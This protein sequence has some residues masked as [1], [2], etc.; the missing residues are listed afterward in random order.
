MAK[1][2]TRGAWL[3]TKFINWF[4]P[5]F[6]AHAFVLARAN[7]YEADACS[8]RL[9]GADAAAGAL[10]RLPVD[11][12]LLSEKFWPDLYARATQEEKPP[13]DVMLLL[14]QALK[15]GPAADDA[16][17]WLKQA[18]LIETNN[19]DTHPCLKDRLRAIGKLPT[20]PAILA[21]LTP[22]APPAQSAAEFFLDDQAAAAAHSM[23]NEWHQAIATQWTARHEHARKTAQE[24]AALE[25]PSD[26]P[27]KP[28]DLWEKARKLIDLHGDA[29]ALPVLRQILALDPKHAAANY[30]CGRHHLEKDEP[31]G[32]Q[33]IESALT[34][35][36]TLTPDGCNLLYGHFARTGQRDRLRPLEERMDQFQDVA[37][38]AQ[39]ERANITARDAFLPGELSATQTA[40]I[41]AVFEPEAEVASAAV[42]RKQVQHFPN[43]A[44]YVVGLRLK[45][46]WWKPRSSTASQKLIN[47]V[48]EKLELPGHFLV[49]VDEQNLRSL[50]KKVFAVPG[51]VV[52]ERPPKN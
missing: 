30:V 5:V 11:G 22:P 16:A 48:V 42:V 43:S 45:T 32:V 44:C 41:R 1:Q 34:T 20:D 35:D 46:S 10:L 12:N 24:L 49:F 47:R 4:W 38:L 18:F 40:A 19:N 36:P 13:T 23:S 25:Q 37:R 26:T 17:R 51:A 27:P 7:E 3:F 2:Q 28:E 33:F 52:F 9:A 39:A 21:A 29:A 50:A 14:G 31:V 8:V 6:N 15:V